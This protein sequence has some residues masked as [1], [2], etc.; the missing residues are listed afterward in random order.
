MKNLAKFITSY[1][2]KNQ[3]S[4]GMSMSNVKSYQDG[5]QIWLF[6]TFDS[7]TWGL[8]LEFSKSTKGHY[9]VNVQARVMGLGE[10]PSLYLP[11]DMCIVSN[12]SNF[13][14]CKIH[15]DVI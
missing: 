13:N 2:L 11:W 8:M 4:D 14:A 10:W 12:T 5:H 9:S 1:V 15:V 6:S 3:I 7:K